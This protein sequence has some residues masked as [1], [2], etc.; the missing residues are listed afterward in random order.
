MEF[1]ITLRSAQREDC[2]S[3]FAWRNDPEVR[4]HIFDPAPIAW[5]DHEQWFN[6][7][8][9]ASDRHLLIG[10]S[11][12]KSIGVIRIEPVDQE[13]GEI[14]VYLVPGNSGQGLGSLLI[15]KGIEWVAQHHP[16]IKHLQA[17][18]LGENAA[19]LKAFQRA[20]FKESYRFYEW[21]AP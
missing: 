8:L 10:D 5:E 9:E 20:G 18:I 19:S 6:K 7:I 21:H 2:K 13:G 15:S 11:E 3:V 4:Q 17:K 14:S 12:G 1:S 16:Q